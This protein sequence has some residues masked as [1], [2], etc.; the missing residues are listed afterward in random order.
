MSKVK[1]YTADQFECAGIRER[2]TQKFD[3]T[4]DGEMAIR[5]LNSITIDGPLEVII[6]ELD[7]YQIFEYPLVANTEAVIN[8]SANT[9]RFRVKVRGNSTYKLRKITG[10][11]YLSVGRGWIWEEDMLNLVSGKS[12]IVEAN[13]NDTLEIIEWY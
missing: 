9:K 3:L 12:F 4:P 11:A 6:S 2:E 10:G 7:E 5:V 13:N 8:I 1:T